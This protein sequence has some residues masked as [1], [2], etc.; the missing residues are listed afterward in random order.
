MA[1]TWT[2]GEGSSRTEAGGA[3]GDVPSKG[4][5]INDAVVQGVYDV[6]P[7]GLTPELG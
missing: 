4:C 6:T 3:K 5:K 2:E 7:S 1:P